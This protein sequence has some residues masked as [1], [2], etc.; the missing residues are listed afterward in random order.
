VIEDIEGAVS[1]P[2]RRWPTQASLCADGTRLNPPYQLMFDAT[3]G[4]MVAL[5]AEPR[6]GRSVPVAFVANPRTGLLT[7]TCAT[8]DIPVPWETI[9]R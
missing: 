6:T 8:S 5:N 2:A 7:V 1:E 4:R 3:S 9:A